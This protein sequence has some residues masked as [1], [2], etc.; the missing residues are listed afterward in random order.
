MKITNASALVW[1]L[2]SMPTFGAVEATLFHI[3]T[4]ETFTVPAGKVLI[5]ETVQSPLGSASSQRLEKGNNSFILRFDDAGVKLPV[6]IPEGWTFRGF[7]DAVGDTTD[8]WVFGLL[9]A[10]SDLFASAQHRID[11]IAINGGMASLG[12]ET[13]SP[14]PAII[15]VETSSEA[16]KEWRSAENA[17]VTPTTDKTRYTAAVPVEGNKGFIRTK[18]R[19]REK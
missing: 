13:M 3:T 5:I 17:V 18:A 12:I 16:D 14:R 2:A 4:N 15:N 11:S 9:V 8:V 10:P 1:L 6:K 7:S 19:P